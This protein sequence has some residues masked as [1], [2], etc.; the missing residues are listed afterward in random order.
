MTSEPKSI[1]IV[2][3]EASIRDGLRD[4]LERAGYRVLTAATIDAA[5]PQVGAADL[6]VLDRRLPD[7]DGL[8]VLRAMRANGSGTP[9]VVLSAL[10]ETD[11]R[12]EGLEDGADDYVTKPFD[13]REL[14]ALARRAPAREAQPNAWREGHRR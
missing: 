1:L 14:L 8:T 11:Q 6:V 13:V 4:C 10:G 3:D 9:V 5:H 12:I 7:G 2:E